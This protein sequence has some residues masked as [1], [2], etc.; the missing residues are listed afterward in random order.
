MDKKS[1]EA[2]IHIPLWCIQ[3]TIG[4]LALIFGIVSGVFG[5]ALTNASRMSTI[6]TKLDLGIAE[7]RGRLV[8]I[9]AI[10]DATNNTNSGAR[11]NP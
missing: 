8:R 1:T 7:L 10:Q 3:T 5:M 6:E 11:P 9:E 2:G 4:L